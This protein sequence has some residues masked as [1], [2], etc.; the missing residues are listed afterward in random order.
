MSEGERKLSLEDLQKVFDRYED[1]VVSLAKDLNE[2]EEAGA[3][4]TEV[5]KR[6]DDKLK[7]ENAKGLLLTE[8]I[9]YTRGY[10]DLDYV[11]KEN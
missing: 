3:D 1:V 7:Q 2:L 10:V 5:Y 4:D 9:G 8:L 11:Y 6:T